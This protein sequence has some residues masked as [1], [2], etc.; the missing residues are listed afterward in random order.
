MT[1]ISV[2]RPTLVGNERRYLLDCLETN[3]LSSAGRYVG[4]FEDAFARFCGVRHAVAVS[5][6]TAALHLALAALG[7]SRGDE[8]IVPTVTYVATANAVRYCGATP[9]LVDVEPRFLTI[10]P[11]RARQ[12][13]T[14]RTKG[15]I[16]VHLY[17]QP[18]A[19]DAINHIAADHGLFVLEDAAEAHGAEVHGVRAGALGTC[20]AFSFFANKIVTTG[21]GGMVT[22]DDD[23]LAEVL[24][25]LRGQG[26]DPTRRYWFPVVGFNY[27]MTNL[28]AAIG[29]A[30]MERVGDAL[31]ARA[32]LASWYDEALA[33][34]DDVLI[35]PRTSP[36]VRS[37][38]WMYTVWLRD[39]D[40]NERDAVIGLLEAEGIE[41]RPVFH[42]LHTLPPHRDRRRFPVA[43]LWAPRGLSLPTHEGVTRAD[44]RR[45]ATALSDALSVSGAPTAGTDPDTRERRVA[46]QPLA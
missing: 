9:V 6:G 16:P 45:I 25:S 21:E 13:I 39:G 46:E 31:R 44:V 29:L 37:V 38:C 36:A 12:R 43:D 32:R 42:P 30:Q 14:G 19:M 7:V 24:R 10:D 27:R 15:I 18:A 33:P 11:R 23:E 8:V 2:G 3:T 41:T 40:A 1:R 28:Q 4:A 20:A 34:L 22:T 17:G 35:R 5:N 26:M